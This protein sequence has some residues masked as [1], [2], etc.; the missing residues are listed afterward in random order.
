ML[1]PSRSGPTWEEEGGRA[2]YAPPS[3]MN[4]WEA[5]VEGTGRGWEWY[6]SGRE[7]G[8]VNTGTHVEGREEGWRH[9]GE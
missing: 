6:R 9:W 2:D 1:W 8:L 7:S 3:D 5:L 4:E